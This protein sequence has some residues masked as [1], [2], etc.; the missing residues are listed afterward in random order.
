MGRWQPGAGGRLQAAA[1]ELYAAHGFESTTVAQIAERA[2]VTERTFFRHFADKREVLFA[3]SDVLREVLL[4]ALH[5]EPAHAPPLDQVGAA[6]RAVAVLLTDLPR[7]RQRQVVIAATPELQERELSKMGFWVAALRDGLRA[8][9]TTE[10]TASLAAEAGV[11]AFRIAFQRWLNH[12]DE[13]PLV[14]HLDQGFDALRALSCDRRTA[15][16]NSTNKAV[17]T[18]S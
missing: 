5:A 12:H 2:G 11:A 18:R 14:A 6:L 8:R 1:L 13:Q 16:A 15:Q 9:H 17:E 3:G 4:T 10:P 7:S